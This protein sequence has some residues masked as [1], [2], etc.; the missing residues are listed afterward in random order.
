[1]DWLPWQK[2][3]NYRWRGVN[4]S[5]T[6]SMRVGGTFSDETLN[7]ATIRK[8][9]EARLH[10]QRKSTLEKEK[11]EMET[12]HKKIEELWSL[13][14]EYGVKDIQKQHSKID[15]KNIEA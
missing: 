13:A 6:H 9:V 11:V 5:F 3:Q 2:A 10:A 12:H 14:E 15:I 8:N 1:M 4:S 7:K